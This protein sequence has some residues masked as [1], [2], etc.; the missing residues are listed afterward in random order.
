MVDSLRLHVGLLAVEDH[1]W[2]GSGVGD[3]LRLEGALLQLGDAGCF[4]DLLQL[5]LSAL[6]PQLLSLVHRHPF[7][8]LPQVL[9]LD[10]AI[11]DLGSGGGLD[12]LRLIIEMHWYWL[13]TTHVPLVDNVAVR[14]NAGELVGELVEVVGKGS[15]GHSQVCNVKTWVLR[16]IYA[17]I[18]AELLALMKGL[19]HG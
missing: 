11:V 15:L 2:L 7:P 4:P 18:G 19:T 16:K 1:G 17:L 13:Q 3:Q 5:L 10:H 12:L 9:V 8:R 14:H 6:V